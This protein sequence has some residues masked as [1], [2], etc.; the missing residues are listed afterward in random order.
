[1]KIND[2]IHLKGEVLIQAIDRDGNMK[3]IIEDKN[4]IV[5]AGRENICNFL[6]GGASSYIND[7]AFGTG[8]TITGNPNVAISVTSDETTLVAPISG[9]ANNADYLF[10]RTAQTTPSPRAVFSTVIPATSLPGVADITQLN[11]KSISELGLMLNTT[12]TTAFAIKRFPAI[13]KSDTIS[14]IITWII[15]V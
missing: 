4:L 3:T 1:M 12:T 6:V 14:L 9:L 2:L 8:G 11:G 13:S 15:Y 7:I 10:T 5:S